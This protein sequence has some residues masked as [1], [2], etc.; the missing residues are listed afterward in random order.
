MTIDKEILGKVSHTVCVAV[1]CTQKKLRKK[2]E[3]LF[4]NSCLDVVRYSRSSTQGLWM[5]TH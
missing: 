5:N 4:V 1:D 2:C 3:D